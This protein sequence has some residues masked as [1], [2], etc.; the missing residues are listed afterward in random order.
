[1]LEVL[2][3]QTT[4]PNLKE[5]ALVD[6][7]SAYLKALARPGSRQLLPQLEALSFVIDVWE[8]PRAAFLHPAASR[9]LV[10]CA[11]FELRDL[12]IQGPPIVNL[13][14]CDRLEK[15]A[16]TQTRSCCKD[17]ND[18]AAFISSNPALPLRRVYLDSS[19]E[20]VSS[21]SNQLGLT[22]TSFRRIC[23]ERRID[24]IFDPIPRNF[25]IDPCFQ[26]NFMRRRR[27]AQ[28]DHNSFG[29]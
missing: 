18:Y 26:P 28:T 6:A 15:V 12:S 17:L 14:L 16:D 25:N 1:M 4:L 24:L 27:T 23:Q 29:S 8:D 10:D 19:L 3:C 7:E 22:L 21:L 2:L 9:T 20:H 5:F 13:R 11:A